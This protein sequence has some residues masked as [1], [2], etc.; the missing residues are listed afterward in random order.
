MGWNTLSQTN[1][2][3][4]D[5]DDSTAIKQEETQ[6]W[7]ANVINLW[8]VVADTSLDEI[9]TIGCYNGEITF[10]GTISAPKELLDMLIRSIDWHQLMADDVRFNNGIFAIESLVSKLKQQLT[11]ARKMTTQYRFHRNGSWSPQMSQIPP[12]ELV[13]KISSSRRQ[14]KLLGNL[15]IS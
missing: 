11:N 1:Q 9:S 14:V 6:W 13:V 10:D 8:K 2:Q 3:I 5:Y 4:G 12:L 7:V 15:L